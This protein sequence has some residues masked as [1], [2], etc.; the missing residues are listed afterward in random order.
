M[1]VSIGQGPKHCCSSNL[2]SDLLL[3]Q[4]LAG[5]VQKMISSTFLQ[6]QWIF[7]SETFSWLHYVLSNI[8][9][10]SCKKE[11]CIY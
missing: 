7:V 10:T 1:K 5:I 8:T 11:N 3:I 9:L 2:S 6:F 4:M